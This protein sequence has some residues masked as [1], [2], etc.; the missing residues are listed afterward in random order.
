MKIFNLENFM[1]ILYAKLPLQ[2]TLS[3]PKDVDNREGRLRCIIG[4][5]LKDAGRLTLCQYVYSELLVGLA[6]SQEI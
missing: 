5:R 6:C 2:D 3:C 1:V 4:S